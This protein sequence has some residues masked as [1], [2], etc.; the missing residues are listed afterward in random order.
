MR[1]NDL[2]AAG[3]ATQRLLAGA[4][5]VVGLPDRGEAAMGLPAREV[6]EAF[7]RAPPAADLPGQL[8][9]AAGL[10]AREP[11]AGFA[12]AGRAGRRSG[13]S[14]MEMRTFR[15]IHFEIQMHELQMH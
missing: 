1:S 14:G 11:V 13:D 9:A 4:C 8:L 10:P 6:S 2:P 3:F 12:P 15:E 7:A 5:P